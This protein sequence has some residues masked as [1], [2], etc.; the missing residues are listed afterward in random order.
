[1]AEK[2]NTRILILG[3]EFGGV[4]TAMTLEK[5]FKKDPGSI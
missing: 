2:S 1:M 3:G 5:L 4:Y